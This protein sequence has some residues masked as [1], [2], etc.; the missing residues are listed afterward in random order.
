L[1]YCSTVNLINIYPDFQ[2]SQVIY[3]ELENRRLKQ[4]AEERALQVEIE[5]KAPP[6]VNVSKKPEQTIKLVGTETDDEFLD[7]IQHMI[8]ATSGVVSSDNE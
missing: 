4:E 8:D 5:E 6:L 2:I 7:K 3:Y 1:N